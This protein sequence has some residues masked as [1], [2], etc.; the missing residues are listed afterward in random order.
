MFAAG[1]DKLNRAGEFGRLVPTLQTLVFLKQRFVLFSHGS[2]DPLGNLRTSLFRVEVR[3]LE[4]QTEHGAI[5]FSH[6]F[7]TSLASRL[8]HGHG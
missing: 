7:V 4:V 5:L 2:L 1:G 8:N 6:Q 3:T